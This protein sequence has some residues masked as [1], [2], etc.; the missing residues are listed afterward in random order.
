VAFTRG[1]HRAAET[2]GIELY[3]HLVVAKGGWTSLRERGVF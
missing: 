2:I 3:D 1:I